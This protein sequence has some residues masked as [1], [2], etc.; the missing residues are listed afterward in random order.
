LRGMQMQVQNRI[1]I[2]IL[3]AVLLIIPFAAVDPAMAQA[4]DSAA[5]IQAPSAS[6]RQDGQTGIQ[7]TPSVNEGKND[8]LPPSR[9][10]SAAPAES[11]VSAPDSAVSSVK[12]SSAVRKAAVSGDSTV[13]KKRPVKKAPPPPPPPVTPP[14][15]S[16]RALRYNAIYLNSGSV[17]NDALMDKFIQRVR[18]TAIN[19]FVMDMKDDMGRLSWRS[20]LPLAALC[21]SNTRRVSDP[22]ALVKKLHDNGLVA[23]ARVVSFKD[24]LLASY[25][26][27]DSTY[28][29]AVLN[30]ASGR[31]WKQDNGEMWI[32][33]YDSRVQE[34]L[35]GV[36]EELLSFGFDQVQMD[37]IRFPTDGK[38]GQLKY[39]VVIDSLEK[40]EVISGFLSRV[41]RAVDK[42]EASLS[43]DV[44]GW[45]PWLSKGREFNIGQD[46]DAIARHADVV[47]PMLYDS[48]FPKSFKSEYG[49]DRA[50]HIVREGTA[51]GVERS[52]KRLTGVQ[53]YIQGFNWRSPHWGT[54]YII[55]Q[56]QAAEDS[57]AVGWI[58]WNAR[59]DYS[60]TW[61]ALAERQN[62]SSAGTE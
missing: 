32:N 39:P 22:A 33:P 16:P 35:I 45:V 61:K 8:S 2:G 14:P 30:T 44:F 42:H 62:R 17:A 12:D 13:Q 50:Y 18:G 47:C 49:Q 40:I 19:G 24:P 57:G 37:Y 3:C 54:R 34:Y 43:V 10:E 11:A 21:G 52:G 41:R 25:A 59:N 1:R 38:I 36:V 58:V 9:P 15:V 7:D 48:H 56:M 31:P 29:Y 60:E 46:Y 5:S 55:R 6:L 4:P 53:P 27:P 28:P 26:G 20:R 23:C 51:K